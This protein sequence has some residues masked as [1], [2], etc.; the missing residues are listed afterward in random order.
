[1]SENTGN[2]QAAANA[3]KVAQATDAASKQAGFTAEP[4]AMDGPDLQKMSGSQLREYFEAQKAAEAKSTHSTHTKATSKADAAK[5][6]DLLKEAAKAATE[7]VRKYKVKVDGQ[8][9]EVD[10]TELLRGYSHQKA[11]NK[12]LQEGTAARKQAEEFVAMMRDPH[13]FYE[14]AQKLGHD[15]RKLAEEY[16]AK[17]L[18]VEL[19][20]PRDRELAEAK[21]KLKHMEDLDR[22]E[23]EKIEAHRNEV[24]KQKYAKDYSDQFVAA[25]QDTGLPPT[26]HMVSDMAKYVSRAAKIGFKMTPAEAAQLVR[27]DVQMAHQRLIGDADGDTLMKLLGDEV[28]NKIRKYDTQ[29]LKNPEQNLRTP[30]EQGEARTMRPKADG[31]RMSPKEWRNYNRK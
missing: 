23:K 10:E 14:T 20:D 9:H 1:M 22:A 27:E 21:N 4:Q 7:A 18:E 6:P 13:K 24:L 3:G 29:R 26:K 30:T 8:E 11:A 12:I 31:K 15:P 16:L 5:G 25:L 17:Q 19:M 28:A 2:A